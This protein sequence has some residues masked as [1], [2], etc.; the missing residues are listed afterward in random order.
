[1]EQVYMFRYTQSTESRATNRGSGVSWTVCRS[2]APRRADGQGLRTSTLCT[3]SVRFTEFT[4]KL[5][6]IL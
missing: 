5:C 4:Y 6:V 3:E 1:M 2:Q